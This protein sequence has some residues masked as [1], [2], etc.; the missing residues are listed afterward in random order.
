MLPAWG[1]RQE[2]ELAVG[3]TRKR[4]L[5]HGLSPEG[6]RRRAGRGTHRDHAGVEAVVMRV[7]TAATPERSALTQTRTV[8]HIHCGTHKTNVFSTRIVLFCFVLYCKERAPPVAASLNPARLRIEE[9]EG[10]ASDI[11]VR[12]RRELRAR[13]DAAALVD[14]EA[15]A[16]GLRSSRQADR[17]LCYI[18]S[19]EI[20]L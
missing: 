16:G 18:I 11:H 10:L 4:M 2:H 1:S 6:R 14:L 8:R 9:A 3:G 20:I 19:G 5:R 15:R 17:V 7:Q 12:A 13:R